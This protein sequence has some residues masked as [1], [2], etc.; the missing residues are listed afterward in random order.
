MADQTTTEIRKAWQLL[1][2]WS[3]A[4]NVKH[5]HTHVR[6]GILLDR[7]KAAEEM[8]ER[9]RWNIDVD[10]ADLIICKG[11]HE[12]H[13]GCDEDRYVPEWKLEASEAKFETLNARYNALKQIHND[14]ND[15]YDNRIEV[16]VDEFTEDLESAASF[17][18]R[19]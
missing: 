3:E 9:N 6:E 13:V 15:G 4:N 5:S 19:L 17:F 12:K 11:E 16:E 1:H 18:R 7:L 14:F 2:D 10:G 8:L